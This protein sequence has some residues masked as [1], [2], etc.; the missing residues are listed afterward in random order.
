MEKGRKA[1]KNISL[2]KER[3]GR[4]VMS[5]VAK[6][7]VQ[8]PIVVFLVVTLGFVLLKTAPGDPVSLFAGEGAS[9]QYLETI[10][11]AYGLDKPILEQ[12][13]T[14]ITGIFVGDW[15]FSLTFERPVLTVIME[16]IPLTLL[17]SF[18]AFGISIP[19]GVVLGMIAAL[20]RNSPVDSFLSSFATFFDSVPAF[21]IGLLLL[22]ALSVSLGILP[23][24]GFMTVGVVYGSL[25]ERLLDLLLH[26]ALPAT[27]LA[28]IWM[29]GYTRVIRNTMIEA[30]LSD[31]VRAAVS[32][33]IKH[34]RIVFK[35]ALRN[36]ILSI[37]TLAGVQVG[38]MLGGV[39][40]TETVFSWFGIGHLVVQAVSFRDYPLLMGVLFFSSIWVTVVNLL[41]DVIYCVVDPRVRLS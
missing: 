33:G 9:P 21:I 18:T 32:R 4:I 30:L 22:Y 27:S 37:V 25:V 3:L 6:R 35:H 24:G 41:V 8:I 1:N 5:Y 15:G 20:R 13:K 31:Y 11:K 28:L 16:R 23:L 29:A 39:I 10:R 34:T 7:L 36:S 26:L 2:K 40:L 17:L 12:Y 38:Y 19:L 14:Y